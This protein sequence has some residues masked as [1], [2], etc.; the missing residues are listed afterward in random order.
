MADYGPSIQAARLYKKTSSKGTIYFAGRWGGLKVAIVKSRDVS[1][2]GEEIWNVLLS[3]APASKQ[4][5]PPREQ[6][7]SEPEA[8]EAKRDHQRPLT[9]AYD[10]TDVEIPF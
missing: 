8:D 2:S 10:A 5:R 1:D 7:R 6:R 9:A 4:D 3:E